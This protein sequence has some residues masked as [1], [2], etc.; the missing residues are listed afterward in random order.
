MEVYLLQRQKALDTKIPEIKTLGTV[1]LLITQNDADEPI[2]TSFGLT[3]TLWV[4]AKVP[5]TKT[6][7][8]WLGANVRLE[9]P[10]EEAVR[11]VAEREYGNAKTCCTTG[12]S[13]NDVLGGRDRPVE[14]SR[15][16]EEIWSTR[17][18]GDT[19]WCW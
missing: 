6:V 3:E 8:L 4:S 10:V 18:D 12:M 5:S 14:S 19:V 7:Y 2:E 16:Y 9:Y 1:D 13:S 15:E 11:F 17:A